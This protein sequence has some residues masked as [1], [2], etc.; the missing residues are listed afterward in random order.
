MHPA[1]I[2]VIVSAGVFIALSILF[3]VETTHGHRFLPRARDIFDRGIEWMSAFIKASLSFIDRKVIRQSVHFILHQLLRIGL[4]GVRLV[5]RR[6]DWLLRR[7]KAVARQVSRMPVE[8]ETT[9][10]K[11][12][13]HKETNA[14]SDAEKRA[15]KERSVG[16]KL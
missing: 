12:A 8:P 14:L 2:S 4:G 9:L 1:F 6:L 7:N 16:T 3:R 11:I 13:K 15:H 5:E 10:D